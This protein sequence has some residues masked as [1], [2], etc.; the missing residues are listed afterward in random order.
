V[1]KAKLKFRSV[2]VDRLSRL[3]AVYLTGHY[4]GTES[5][6][7]V[8]NDP[9]TVLVIGKG[10]TTHGEVY[11]LGPVLAVED[12]HFMNNVTGADLVWFVDRSFPRGRTVGA[13]VILALTAVHSQM[14][15]VSKHVWHGDYGWRGPKNSPGPA[16]KDAG[17]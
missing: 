14:D 7:F 4:C 17:K 12:A 13:P 11:S 15:V 8:N 1:G 5:K 6:D 10:F 3:K 9:D 2:D 16:K